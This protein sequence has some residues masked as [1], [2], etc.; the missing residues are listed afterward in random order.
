MRFLTALCLLALLCTL[1]A[2]ARPPVQRGEWEAAARAG[3]VSAQL[4][5]GDVYFWGIGEPRDLGR[6]LDWYL[7]AARQNHYRGWY[8]ASLALAQRAGPGDGEQAVVYGSEAARLCAEQ[9]DQQ[10]PCD[11]SEIYRNIAIYQTAL[12][13][14]GDASATYN[15]ALA[16]AQK[17]GTL[18]DAETAA[19]LQSRADLYTAMGRYEDALTGYQQALDLFR[20]AKGDETGEVA[21][22]LFG[23]AIA[24]NRNK[25]NEKAV[26]LYRESIRIYEALYGSGFP[27]I[28]YARAN[29]GWALAEQKR[30]DEAYAESAAALPLVVGI[31]GENGLSTAYVLNNMGII[32]ERQGLHDA[33]I[34]LNLRAAAIYNRYPEATLDA[35]RW[36]Y[37]S[38]ALSY[39]AQGKLGPAILMGKLAVNAHQAIRAKNSDLTSDAASSLDTGWQDLYGDLSSMLVE[40]GRIAE[41]QYVLN[42]QKRQELVEF[43][44]R[45]AAAASTD[46][47]ALT[48]HETEGSAALAHA[49]EQPV[50]I[51]AELDA[52]SAK[53]ANGTATAEEI[54]RIGTLNTALDKSYES[55][56]AEVDTLLQASESEAAG[57]RGEITALNLDYAADRQE[58]LKGFAKPT[59]LLQAASL[60]DTLHLFLTTKDISIHRE[61]KI[62]RAALSKKVFDALNAIAARDPGADALLAGLYDDLVRPVEADLRASG[63]EVIMLNL[64]GFLRYLPFAALKSDHGYL[65]EDY[66]IAFDTPAAR[67]NFETA[68]RKAATAAGFGVTAAHPGFSPL[69]GVASELEAIFK[70]HDDKGELTGAPLLDSDFTEDSLKAALKSRPRL[71]H[72]ASH[73]KFVPGNETNSFLLL[74]NGDALTLEQIRKGRGFRF[75][76][77]DLLTLSACETARG[78]DG[79]GGEVESFGAIAQMNG[80]SAVM[81]TLWPIAD[82]ASGKLMADFYKGLVEDG[83]D[84]ADALRRAQIAMLRGVDVETVKLTTRGATDG[85]EPVPVTAGITTRHPYY[86]SPYI[87]MGNW[88]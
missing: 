13:R 57:A 86:W 83:L 34:R 66:A 48:K 4:H 11:L 74:G 6:A 70:G 31:D 44:R 17:D 79:D 5:L 88:L 25:D 81:A 76:G 80:A 19:L 56:V 37:H 26:A 55:F 69:P 61:V 18:A 67:T 73:F 36:A 63:A 20:K 38:L 43:V 64:G 21:N 14:Y 12:A 60:G 84:K 27:N 16:A 59:V 35:K 51:A 1:P 65:I 71:L 33:A 53:Q 47:A 87:L 82:E 29:I 9:P 22:T 40:A 54:V 3:T 39:R 10:P 41:A 2:A 24:L 77:V 15:K 49:M 42:L 28:A 45:D 78:G 58:M 85:E 72:V 7:R 50:A 62:S 75:G 23:A 32:R 52:L 68:D 46:A 30:Y 8:M